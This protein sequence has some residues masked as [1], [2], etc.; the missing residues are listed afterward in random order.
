MTYS[1][2]ASNR[3]KFFGAS[4]RL[5]SSTNS[6]PTLCVGGSSIKKTVKSIDSLLMASYHSWS[7]LV[8]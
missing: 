8:H 4:R 1:R 7:P 2:F 6:N 5:S 3:Q